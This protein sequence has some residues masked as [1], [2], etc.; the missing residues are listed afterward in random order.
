MRRRLLGVASARVRLERGSIR[1]LLSLRQPGVA[2]EQIDAVAMRVG[3]TGVFAQ[4]RDGVR[5][6]VRHGGEPLTVS[7]RSRVK[8][9]R[10]LLGDPPL[11]VVDGLDAD[12]DD[13]GRRVLE[14]VLRDYPGVAVVVC[15]SSFRD[16]LDAVDWDLEDPR[17][18]AQSGA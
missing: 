13:D 2:D 3:L 17:R 6:R 8:L 14:G 5:T 11:L 15:S 1:R 4:L 16:R 7:Q 18:A 9:G 12:L 10:A